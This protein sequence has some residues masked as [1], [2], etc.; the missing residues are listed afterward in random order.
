MVKSRTSNGL[1]KNCLQVNPVNSEPKNLLVFKHMPS[2]NPGI[3]RSIGKTHGVTFHEIDLHAGDAIPDIE[4]FDGLWV[5]GGSMNTW[6]EE[7][8]PWL[9]EEKNI[10]RHVVK[11]LQMP[12]L[13]ICFG[14]QLL[15]DALGGTVGLCDYQELGLFEI[16]A[17]ESGINHPLLDNL[18][19][20]PGWANVHTAEV[21]RAPDG[22]IILARSELCRN[23]IMSVDNNAYSVQFHPEVCETTVP[24][25]LQI[26]GIPEF[27]ID[28]LEHNG[29]EHFKSDIENNR[30][31]HNAGAEQLFNN[32]MSLVYN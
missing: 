23:H 16:T 28:R 13:G 21:K 17:T 4:K 6:D 7:E 24:D 1:S 22:A 15:A 32:W 10:I 3:F 9:I 5:M 11:E 30:L 8:Y 20:S 25:W 12:Y 2:Q 19:K 27:L 14:H 26:P 31:A 29:F 18:P